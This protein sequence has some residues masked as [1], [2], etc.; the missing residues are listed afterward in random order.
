MDPDPILGILG[1][2]YQHAFDIKY[3]MINGP[4]QDSETMWVNIQYTLRFSS[5]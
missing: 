3:K 2:D 5:I 1:K 4:S